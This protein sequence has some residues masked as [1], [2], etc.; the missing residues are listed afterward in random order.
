VLNLIARARPFLSTDKFT[1]VTPTRSDSSVSVMP[2]SS[3]S[4]SATLPAGA[5]AA[6][7]SDSL[8][9]RLIGSLIKMGGW[10]FQVWCDDDRVRRSALLDLTDTFL[11]ARAKT[12]FD[13]AAKPLARFCRQAGF[14]PLPPAEIAKLARAAG[15]KALAAQLDQLAELSGSTR[16]L[17]MLNYRYLR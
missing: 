5:F 13:V 10:Y 9:P 8:E 4:A 1:I 14:S 7:G 16:R 15:R 12:A 6:T 2:R 3:S 11:G 17:K